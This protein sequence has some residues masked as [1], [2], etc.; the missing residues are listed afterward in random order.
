MES[1]INIGVRNNTSFPQNVNLLGGTSDPLGIPPS[2]L[3]Q[4]DLSTETYFG[5]VTATIVISNT[6]NPTPITYTVQ[7]NGYNIQSVAFALNTLNLGVFQV[8]GNIIYVSNDFYIYGALS[9]VSNLFNSTWNTSNTSFGS[10]ASNQIALP[11][12]SS[13]SYNFV[14]DWGDG[15]Q[16]TITVW[17]QSETTHTY[18]NAGTYSISI[19]GECKGFRFN[20]SG[21]R[22]KI[23]SVANWGE[24]KLIG[25]LGGQFRGCSNLNL[26]SVADVLNFGNCTSCENMFLGGYQFSTINNIDSW[27]VSNVTN[28]NSMFQNT[29]F[30]SYIGSWNVG[31]VTSMFSMFLSSPFNQNIGSWN[32][33]NVITMQQMFQ[34]ATSFNGNIGSWNV[35]N[36]TN[37]QNMF[38]SATS[39]NQSLNSWNVSSV[40]NM[41]FMFQNAGAFNGNIS[42]W[43]TP[44]V[45]NMNGMFSGA[46][47]FNQNLNAWDVSSVN[48]MASM[49]NGATS[50]NGNI[51][52]WNVGSVVSISG[53]FANAT[54]FNQNI[55]SWN[56][57]NVDGTSSMFLNATSFNQNIGS[58]D[59]SNAIFMGSMFSGATSFNQNIGSW[60]VSNATSMSG[61]FE[62]A[63]AF[64]QNLNAWDV[65]SVNNM[66][67]MFSSATSFNQNIG[68]WNVGSVTNMSVMFRNATSFNQNIGSWDISNVGT[69]FLFMNG[70]TDLNYSSANLDAIYNGWS[71]LSVQ[72]N[73]LA[74]F[75]TIKYTVAGQAG[76]NILDFA[77]N[78]WTITDGGI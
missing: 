50:F 76:K 58:W 75:G 55:G 36:V 11:L 73:V 63:T 53:I 51:G 74:D 12:F 42:A 2:L 68:S 71:L 19:S 18:A 46:T 47:S 54:S 6:S 41:S 34:N 59:V 62:N 61:M 23:L 66:A 35:G 3:Y 60:N 4:W 77:P 27:D 69:F 56:V 43:N 17:N 31:S 21:D 22:L 37:M 33:A 48:N 26:T 9:V 16:D 1:S 5:S 14:V 44:N 40:T 20:G 32:T 7:V 10:S 78:N 39:F 8:S 29:L 65:S 67:S 24:F 49:F 72:A 38:V 45:V 25:N 64:N 52:S 70:K 28:M 30:N 15:S 57:S 13:G